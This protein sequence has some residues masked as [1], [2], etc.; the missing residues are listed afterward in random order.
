MPGAIVGS[1]AQTAGRRRCAGIGKTQL[2][3]QLA[4][5]VHLPALFGGL[6]VA[7]ARGAASNAP[8][9][10]VRSRDAHAAPSLPGRQC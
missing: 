7:F 8:S 2:G 3:I 9:P 4:V 5:D 10:L 6:Q 1:S